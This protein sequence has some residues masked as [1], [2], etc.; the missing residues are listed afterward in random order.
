MSWG[1]GLDRVRR[2]LQE[3]LAELEELGE[4]GS[5][6]SFNIM[7]ALDAVSA[8]PEPVDLAE[9][10]V[11]SIEITGEPASPRTYAPW[12]LASARKTIRIG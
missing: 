9:L 1:S 6:A 11:L 5:S 4:G 7:L 12:P 3:A 8:A 2:C 10:D